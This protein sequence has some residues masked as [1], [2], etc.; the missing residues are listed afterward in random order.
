MVELGETVFEKVTADKFS[1]SIYS[2]FLTQVHI[3]VHI[4][5][6]VVQRILIFNLIQYSE[7]RRS[8]ITLQMLTSVHDCLYCIHQRRHLPV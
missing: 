4:D 8:K 7:A 5:P 2:H 3:V 6:C 1:L